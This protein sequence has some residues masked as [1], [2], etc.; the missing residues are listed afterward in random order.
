MCPFIVHPGMPLGAAKAPP[1]AAGLNANAS[2]HSTAMKSLTTKSKYGVEINGVKPFRRV[3]VDQVS[4]ET[5]CRRI[6]PPLEHGFQAQNADCYRG[7]E[8][9]ASSLTGSA[10]GLLRMDNYPIE[11]ADEIIA[12]IMRSTT[13]FT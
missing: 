10:S 2:A 7:C 11:W 4:A 5:C 9:K 12:V 6:A 3:S 8:T 13:Q 1:V